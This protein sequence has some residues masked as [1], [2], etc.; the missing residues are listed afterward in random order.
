MSE[1]RA[2]TY[3]SGLGEQQHPVALLEPQAQQGLH[4]HQLARALP[5][6]EVLL[7]R[8]L[9]VGDVPQDARAPRQQVRVVADLPQRDQNREDLQGSESRRRV[10]RVGDALTDGVGSCF[11]WFFSIAIEIGFFFSVEI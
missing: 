8:E 10:S 7:L 3:L 6:A 9:V 11:L 5:V 4:H 2:R 1:R